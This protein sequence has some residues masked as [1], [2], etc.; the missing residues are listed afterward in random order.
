VLDGQRRNTAGGEEGRRPRRRAGVPDEGLA[1]TGNQG[2]QEHQGEV[3][4]QFQYP[5]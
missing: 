3:R 2:V 5:I 4:G 1:N